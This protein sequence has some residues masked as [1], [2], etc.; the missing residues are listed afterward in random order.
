MRL[1]L[2]LLACLIPG[3]AFAACPL[4]STDC[5]NPTYNNIN[6]NTINGLPPGTATNLTSPGPIGTVTPGVG[7]F[8]TLNGLTLTPTTGTFTLAVGK[9]FK[10]DNTLE[11]AGTD[12]TKFTFPATTGTVATLNTTNSFSVRQFFPASIS[13]GSSAG[14]AID[15]SLGA[16]VGNNR[17]IRFQG[18]GFDKWQMGAGNNTSTGLNTDS[19]FFLGAYSD[20][21]AFLSFALQANRSSG[22]LG[23]GSAMISRLASWSQGPGGDFAVLP[24]GTVAN[25]QNM[26]DAQPPFPLPT[27]SITTT[28]PTNPTILT[29]ALPNAVNVLGVIASNASASG[30]TETYIKLAGATAVGGVTP[31]GTWLPVNYISLIETAATWAGGTVTLTMSAPHGISVGQT[32]LVGDMVPT[33]YNGTYIATAGTAGSTI[34]YALAA[35]PGAVTVLGTVWDTNRFQVTWTS[36]ATSAATGGGA[37]ITATP[38]YAVDLNKTA[39]TVTSAA[40]GFN[41]GNLLIYTVEPQFYRPIAGRVGPAYQANWMAVNSPKDTS[42]AFTFGTNAWEI[43]LINRAGDEGYAPVLSA[44]QRNTIGL[45]L[46]PT[47]PQGGADGTGYHWNTVISCFAGQASTIGVYDCY[48]WQPNSIV[49]AAFD[50]IISHGGVGLDGFQSYTALGNPGLTSFTAGT[51]TVGL[52]YTNT[53]SVQTEIVGNTVYV[54]GS[55]TFNGLTVGPGEYVINAI[56]GTVLTI[57]PD[58]KITG[59][60]SGPGTG[61]GAGIITSFADFAPYAPTQ[62]WGRSKHGYTTNENFYSEDGMA[63]STNHYNGFGFCDG[64]NWCDNKAGMFSTENGVGNMSVDLIPVGTG[65][66]NIKGLLNLKPFLV[67]A[68]PACSATT[69]GSLAYVTDA[70]AAPVYNATVAAGSTV[71]TSVFCNGTNWTNH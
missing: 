69:K 51:S 60:S 48:S 26:T 29:I 42:K 14:G 44:I 50:T 2:T 13:D 47:Q 67:S 70:A 4:V 24:R 71:A 57:G 34:T 12:G 19:S 33:A 32:V 41:D 11:F 8:T 23:N 46:G 18:G 53:G 68:L 52:N 27:N 61:G 16:A 10:M 7:V 5:P 54:Y 45:W 36:P 64:A 3:V 20:T 62:M 37:A 6:V 66:V 49:P 63:Y 17:A 35:N 55:H 43:D 9:T 58:A 56:S 30:V 21:G 31:N 25:Q 65:L 1:V 40:Q 22:V 39:Y 59:T 38:M 15:L 28:F